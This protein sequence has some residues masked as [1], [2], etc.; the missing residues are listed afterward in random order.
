MP[1]SSCCICN[2]SGDSFLP[3]FR[4]GGRLCVC[5]SCRSLDRNRHL[6]EVLT[7]AGLPG[8]GQAVLDIAPSISIL[9]QLAT[10]CVYL[11][12]DYS[13]TS[14]AVL[15]GDL[16]R[17]P[18]PDASFDIVLC[19]HVLEHVRDDAAAM[20][21]VARVL[22]PDGRAFVQVPYLEQGKTEDLAEMDRHG[23][24]RN[25][26]RDD[27]VARLAAAGMDV[28]AVNHARRV[29]EQIVNDPLDVFVCSAPGAVDRP[30]VL[31]FLRQLNGLL[32]RNPV[33]DAANLNDIRHVPMST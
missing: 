12:V 22:R 16:R 8:E 21:E 20:R 29:G 3:R 31:E 9:R 23:H 18:F 6:F 14:P 27:F 15:P 26:G 30:P 32:Y 33:H 4:T 25:Y 13:P 5:P 28:C 7:Q 10:R 1:L 19:S 24:V 2:W 11:A 17:L